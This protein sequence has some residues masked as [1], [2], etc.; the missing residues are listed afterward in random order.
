MRLGQVGK[1]NGICRD[2]CHTHF[3]PDFN[4]SRWLRRPTQVP[5]APARPPF[6]TRENVLG[7]DEEFLE[8]AYWLI[9]GRPIDDEWR[10]T[11]LRH[12]ELG[13]T[14]ES[15]IQAT[16]GSTE[17]R[18]RYHGYH[19]LIQP[20]VV[21]PGEAGLEE[22]LLALGTNRAFLDAC[23]LCLFGRSPDELGF[24]YYLNRLEEHGEQRTKI[25][26]VF[27]QSDEFRDRYRVLCP[28]GGTVPVDVQLCELAN[29]AKWD[30]PDW[31]RMLVALHLPAEKKLAMHRKA[32][33]F[34]QTAWGLDR[35]GA[36]TDR[37]AIL[38]VGAG[39]E[40][41]AY[42]LAN[43]VRLVVA[44]DLYPGDWEAS[45]GSEGDASVLA[46]PEAFAPF[47]YRRERLRFLRMDGMKLAFR[48]GAFDI[49]YSLSSI[50]HFGGFAGAR[51]A[52]EEMARVL[53]PGG[54]LALATEWH[55]SGPSGAHEGIFEPAE[56]RALIDLPSLQLIEPI[57]DRVWHRY[58]GQPVDLRLNRYETPHMLVEIDGTVFTSVMMFLRKI[59]TGRGT[60][61]DLW[62]TP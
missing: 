19:D 33:E 15:V 62:K 1:I 29:P 34:T 42:W 17:F 22:H 43:R 59:S 31:H 11:R 20:D 36:L 9:L 54:V 48:D 58:A 21:V 60:G 45:A 7:T 24:G 38:S 4:F 61:F 44:T 55:V 53:T 14:R 12:L 18:Q 30:N 56:V 52:V 46:R 3:V 39:H 2:A 50:E 28:A 35:L 8:T 26:Y 47:P 23:Y 57:D 6:D 25:V 41:L 5:A 40:S 49:A 13:H 32:Y 51:Q 37:A 16:F 10:R 27:L